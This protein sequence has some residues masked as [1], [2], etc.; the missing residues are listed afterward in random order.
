MSETKHERIKNALKNLGQEKN[1]LQCALHD[2]DK[3]VRDLERQKKNI[4]EMIDLLNRKEF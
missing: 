4:Q 2:A 1:R 3:K